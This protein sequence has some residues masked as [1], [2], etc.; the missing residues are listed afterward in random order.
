M[1]TNDTAH[2]P[3]TEERED[4][5]RDLPGEVRGLAAEITQI[6]EENAALRNQMAQ[7]R[8]TIRN[9]EG[10]NDM[11]RGEIQG[12]K[13]QLYDYIVANGGLLEEV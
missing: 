2:V 3:T 4:L 13:A 10:I 7:L 1:T 12:Y 6:Q 9:M 11:L 8:Q 5:F